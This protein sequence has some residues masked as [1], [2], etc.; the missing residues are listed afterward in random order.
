MRILFIILGLIALNPIS[1]AQLPLN[2]SQIEK[3]TII[4]QVTE[5]EIIGEAIDHLLIS[6]KDTP[7]DSI[8]YTTRMKKNGKELEIELESPH[9]SVEISVPEGM[10]LAVKMERNFYNEYDN[11]P[12]NR[13]K[14]FLTNLKADLEF[15]ANGYYDVT[16]KNLSGSVSLVTYGHVK[17]D[18]STLP[19]N[20]I[21]SIDTY[22]GNVEVTIP[23]KIG[24]QFQ[25]TAKDGKVDVASNVS[26]ESVLE[27]SS[28]KFIGQI[29]NGGSTQIILHS[30][31]GKYVLLSH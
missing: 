1:K 5:F 4:G 13:P 20:G 30:E 22:R 18:F 27:K 26:V 19:E 28:Q 29:G 16:L 6:G 10:P 3:I 15:Y 31:A 25:M 8:D 9:Y 17:A 23:R 7:T 14:A 11:G 24:S 12:G 2:V 21:L